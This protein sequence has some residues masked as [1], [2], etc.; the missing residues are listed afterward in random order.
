MHRVVVEIAPDE[1]GTHSVMVDT[2][3]DHINTLEVL[4]AAQKA[5]I[6][7]M[8]TKQEPK[9]EEPPTPKIQVVPSL[10]GIRQSG[11]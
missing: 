11:N 3:F 9:K 6:R 8:A 5:I 1:N 2:P 10:N 4:N 7:E